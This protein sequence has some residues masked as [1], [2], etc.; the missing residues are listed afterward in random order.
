MPFRY[1]AEPFDP[2]N[3]IKRTLSGIRVLALA[4]VPAGKR[5]HT[6]DARAHT[7]LTRVCARTCVRRKTGERRKGKKVVRPR[8]D[9]F[10][11]H[12]RV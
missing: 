1:L 11:I 4:T 2:S 9:H 3:E 6:R 5:N 7:G 8:V 10:G 12:A